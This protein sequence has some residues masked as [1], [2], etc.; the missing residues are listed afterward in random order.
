MLYVEH[1][2]VP[3]SVLGAGKATVAET[4][5]EDATLAE[6]GHSEVGAQRC[7]EVQGG[8]DDPHPGGGAS[9]FGWLPGM[10]M[11]CTGRGSEWDWVGG[12]SGAGAWG[13]WL[14]EVRAGR[15]QTW[16]GTETF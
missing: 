10:I 15:G 7:R 13:D 1:F 11:G 4:L 2:Y 9:L 12:H 6:K 5:V 16:E 14:G 3:D 8:H